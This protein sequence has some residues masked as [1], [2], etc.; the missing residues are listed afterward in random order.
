MSEHNTNL[1]KMQGERLTRCRK[2][3]N[4]TQQQL[5]DLCNFSKEYISQLEHGKKPIDYNKAMRFAEKMDVNP[6]F[7]MCKSDFIESSGHYDYDNYLDIDNCFLAFLRL[8][9]FRIEFDV[10]NYLDSEKDRTIKRVPLEDMQGVSMGSTKTKYKDGDIIK[11]IM[12][13]SVYVNDCKL[14]YPAFSFTI[15]RLYDYIEFTF[16]NMKNFIFDYDYSKAVV[17]ADNNS[18]CIGG[19][20]NQVAGFTREQLK[21][22]ASMGALFSIGDSEPQSFESFEKEIT[23]ISQNKQ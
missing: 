10:Y 8:F 22:L 11:D 16:D 9:G 12:I 7:I 18:I 13:K 5:G 23:K 21:D 20:E 14:S 2:Y 19:A 15:K 6:N 3:R 4:L 17:S 1:T